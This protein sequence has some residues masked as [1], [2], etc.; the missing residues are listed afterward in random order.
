MQVT[1][2][3]G[4]DVCVFAEV[5]RTDTPSNDVPVVAAGNVLH[6]FEFHDVHDL[7]AD[8]SGSTHCLGM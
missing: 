4:S 8:F 5:A 7:L 6:L 2:E 1:R 3:T